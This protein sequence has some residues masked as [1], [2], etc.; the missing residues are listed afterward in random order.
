MSTSS[1][2]CS[3]CP[4]I[5]TLPSNDVQEIRA[6]FLTFTDG[7]VAVGDEGHLLPPQ[8]SRFINKY[9]HFRFRDD[10]V[11]VMTFPRSGTTWTQ[12]L[13]WC[14]THNMDLDTAASTPLPLRSP[15]IEFDAL[16]HPG[17]GVEEILS[18][19]FAERHPGQDP[20]QVGV[21]LDSAECAKSPRTLHT[22]LPF[23]LLPPCLLDTCK[24][25]YVARNPRDTCV[26]YYY[27]QRLMKSAEYVGNFAEF[28]DLWCRNLVL[29]APY[30]GHVSE[31][32]ERRDHPNF[33]WLY[34]EDMKENLPRELRRLDNFLGTGLTEDQ[35]G[36]LTQ[37]GSFSRMKNSTATNFSI[38][39]TMA[40]AMMTNDK[41]SFVRKGT[42]GDWVSHFT[43][44]LEAKFKVWET[45]GGEVAKQAAFSHSCS[46]LP[47]HH[48]RL[49][50]I[51][52]L[53]ISD[54]MVAHRC[55]LLLVTILTFLRYSDARCN[56]NQI[57]CRVGSRCVSYTQV[58]T[59]SRNCNDG[60][61]EDPEICK[62][63]EYDDSS[64]GRNRGKFY[65][66]FGEC[67]TAKDACRRY[68]SSLDTRICKIV[69]SGKLV[70]NPQP[71][72]TPEPTPE[73]RPAAGMN[74][75]EEIMSNLST[76]V[77]TT[78][79]SDHHQCP[80][81][82]V[83]VGQM[84]IAFFSPAKVSWAE[85]RQFCL[86][87]YGDLIS[88]TNTESYGMILNYMKEALLTSSYWLGGRYDMDTN[89][90]AWVHDDSPMPL[91]SP[92]WTMK[93]SASCVPRSPPHTDPFSS[94][95][96]P[97]PGAPCYHYL[98][99]PSQRKLG[100]CSA[101]TY[102]NFYYISDEECEA[103]HSPLCLLNHHD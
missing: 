28:V 91:G 3:C 50:C 51:T 8:C 19:Q 21:F 49:L 60:S 58:C 79:R 35:L 18:Q 102:E 5:K 34:Y 12:E 23:S 6:K 48:T 10:D 57:E 73:P 7:L 37:H 52:G 96:D 99:A 83:P 101:M 15:F 26:S 47:S 88:F 68:P 16:T 92:Y 22:H 55:I 72:P 17:H 59:S 67:L 87:I 54:V 86:S 9:H 27:H 14:M 80:M 98:Q 30:W 66:G 81:L 24:V 11:L 103:I 25:V 84:C 38:N 89:S 53:R 13:V 82:Y 32:W 62:F 78:L 33:L 42:T 1:N 56:S 31:A 39:P 29:Q 85:A 61:D 43:P 20:K 100:W 46:S 65:R 95:A 63:W 93:Y 75:S 40:K 77:N 74:V 97:L 45:S 4:S 70:Y 64:C 71:E 94:P 44:E 36:Q 2:S 69:A 90:W 41:S 76:A